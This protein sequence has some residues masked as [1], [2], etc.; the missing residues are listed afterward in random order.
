MSIQDKE[1]WDS[2]YLKKTKLLEPREASKNL[3]N[4]VK[5]AKGYEALDLA[6]G[7]GRNSIFLAQNGF[8]VDAIDIATIALKALESEALKKDV[9]SKINTYCTD[10]DIYEIKKN[11]YNF[12]LM[13]NFLDRTLLKSAMYALKDEGILFV[14]TYMLSE[15]NEKSPSNQSYLL[16]SGELKSM[17]DNSWEI[18]HFDEFENEDY[19]I[20]KM[21]KQVLVAKKVKLSNKVF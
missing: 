11:K 17:L 20:Y 13:S 15:E 4:S 1:K 16:K 14:E 5:Y 19:E 9:H 6:C 7:A 10:L 8:N 2:K 18:L 3:Q 12:I 21:K